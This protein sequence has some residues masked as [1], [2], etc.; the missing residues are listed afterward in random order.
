MSRDS[1]FDYL[2]NFG[3]FYCYCGENPIISKDYSGLMGDMTELLVCSAISGV[4]NGTIGFLR[5]GGNL[6]AGIKG[7]AI[8]F[9]TAFLGG[10]LLAETTLF[11]GLVKSSKFLIGSVSGGSLSAIGVWR[12]FGSRPL[13]EGETLVQNIRMGFYQ[14]STGANNASADEKGAISIQKYI[15]E[16]ERRLGNGTIRYYDGTDLSDEYGH[17]IG[18]PVDWITLSSNVNELN[19]VQSAL[20][21]IHEIAHSKTSYWTWPIAGLIYG[22]QVPYSAQY[23]IDKKCAKGE[24]NGSEVFFGFSNDYYSKISKAKGINLGE[25]DV[26]MDDLKFWSKKVW[27]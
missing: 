2:N 26:T 8:G 4:L 1:F 23:F 10:Y 15:G 25:D 24:I 21:V 16:F 3:N 18:V 22:E 14:L 12:L 7:F 19:P 27:Q 20:V 5:S 17:Y 9:A 13:K 11:S 6:V